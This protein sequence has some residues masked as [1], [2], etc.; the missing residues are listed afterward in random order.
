VVQVDAVDG[1]NYGE[2]PNKIQIGHL[3][4][5]LIKQTGGIK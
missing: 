2:I 1:S 3:E 5:V 4:E